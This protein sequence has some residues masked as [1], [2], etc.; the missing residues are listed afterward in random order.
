[1]IPITKENMTAFN[2]VFVFVMA[3]LCVYMGFLLPEVEGRFRILIVLPIFFT[4]CYGIT[5]FLTDSSGYDA[6]TIIMMLLFV[7]D[8]LLP[9]SVI[10]NGKFDLT[11]FNKEI[12]PHIPEAVAMQ[13]IEI[14]FISFTVIFTKMR[15]VEK[16][17][18]DFIVIRDIDVNRLVW[19]VIFC[20]SLVV[21]ATMVINPSMLNKMRPLFFLDH[22]KE[23]EWKKK[24]NEAV[25]SLSPLIYYPTNWLF[26]VTR[27]SF[28]YLLSIEIWKK[29]GEK[30]RTLSLL[31][32][33]GVIGVILIYF[34]P[35]DVMA[36]II[37]AISMFLLVTKLYPEKR[38]IIV[39]IICVAA[40][41]LFIFMFLI[42]PLLSSDDSSQAFSNLSLRLNA[43][44]SGF[45]NVAGTLEMDRGDRYHRLAGDMLRSLPIIKGFFTPWPRSM[46]LF[47]QALGVDPVYNSQVVPLEGQGYY[48]LG[49]LGVVI[50]PII[51]TKLSFHYYQKLVNAKGTYSFFSYCFFTMLF[52]LGLVMYDFFLTVYLALS[53]APLLM[54]N[55]FIL[56]RREE[57]Q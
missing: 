16:G 29:L 30:A 40:A 10:L 43:Y 31:L 33:F 12:I 17:S 49:Y 3:L 23:I 18:D 54:I 25:V 50:M 37:A 24:A 8:Y 13:L 36:S 46:E 11:Q 39:E 7:K 34:V 28:T 21:L 48:Y 53:Y 32:I 52:A 9:F 27:M 26:V 38:K 51:N 20:C 1:M 55:N 35:D 19:K 6:K 14:Y 15:G 44:F 45:A 42:K 2:A 41:I 57:F 4:I 47:N 56:K 5:M 22:E